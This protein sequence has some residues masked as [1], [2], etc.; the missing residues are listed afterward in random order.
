MLEDVLHMTY[1][2]LFGEANAI[3]VELSEDAQAKMNSLM[4]D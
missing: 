3:G 1:L 4:L 2:P